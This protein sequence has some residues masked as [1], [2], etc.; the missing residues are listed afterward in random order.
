[1]DL[2]NLP[3]Q[4][5]CQLDDLK[6]FSNFDSGNLFRVIRSGSSS[7][8]L[9]IASDA[10]NRGFNQYRT[11]FHFGILGLKKKAFIKLSISPGGRPTS[12]AKVLVMS[13]KNIASS[14]TVMRPTSCVISSNSIASISS[15]RRKPVSS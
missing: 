6:F 14:A 15:T 9:Y 4:I 1:M 2:I 13:E 3:Q 11:W 8:E 10:Q 12:W 7:Y 5:E